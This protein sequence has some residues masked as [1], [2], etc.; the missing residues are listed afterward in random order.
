MFF[1]SFFL[2]NEGRTYGQFSLIHSSLD[3]GEFVAVG[4]LNFTLLAAAICGVCTAPFVQ[5][6][7]IFLRV[8]LAIGHRR[9]ESGRGSR[10]FWSLDFQIKF[11][12]PNR[13]FIFRSLFHHPRY[14]NSFAKIPEIPQRK[15]NKL[16]CR[17]LFSLRKSSVSKSNS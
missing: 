6:L 9:P 13:C 11:E 12:I 8:H 2:S 17:C 1:F 3:S 16:N 4:L 10:Q 7:T 14:S 15:F 5:F